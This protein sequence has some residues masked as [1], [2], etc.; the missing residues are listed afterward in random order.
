VRFTILLSYPIKEHT[1]PIK[2]QN[3]VIMIEHDNI[4]NLGLTFKKEDEILVLNFKLTIK[5]FYQDII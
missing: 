4:L 3:L 2:K 1:L 5:Y